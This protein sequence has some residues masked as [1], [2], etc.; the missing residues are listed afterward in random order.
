[1]LFSQRKG[2]VPIKKIIQLDQVDDE[3]RYGLW[4]SL[5]TT[6]YTKFQATDYPYY[7]AVSGSNLEVLFKQYWHSFFKL[8]IDN[9]PP[10]YSEAI[11]RIREYFLKC[12]WNEI[13]DFIEFTANYS[14]NDFINNFIINCN[15][16][17]E[18]E[19]SGYR[20][21]G[22]QIIEISSEIEMNS[23]EETLKLSSPIHSV[24]SHIKAAISLLSDRKNPDFRNSIKESISA[25]EAIV[26]ILS[27][28]SNSTLGEALKLFENENKLHPAFK[29]SL[30]S[31]YGYTSVLTK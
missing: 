13:Y 10:L 15:G 9:L 4:N 14:P 2:L 19:N 1:M 5:Y 7:Q 11:I 30:S 17:L 25:V 27:G 3:L 20:F 28:K 16:I 6:I 31:L 8:P 26:K 29:N 21:V 24:N 12:K 23:I 18:R 22:R